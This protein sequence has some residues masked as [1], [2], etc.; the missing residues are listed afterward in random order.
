MIAAL[1]K[2][3]HDFVAADQP[4]SARSGTRLTRLVELRDDPE[5]PVSEKFRKVLEALLVETEY[6]NT[7]EVYQETINTGGGEMLVD[8][9]RLGRVGLFYQS[10]R[11]YILRL[12]QCRR[13]GLA[14]PAGRLPAA[15]RGGH[16]DRCQTAAGGTAHPAPREDVAVMKIFFQI[17]IVPVALFFPGR[18]ERRW[19][20]GYAGAA[21]GPG[22]PRR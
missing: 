15:D 22:T 10:P 13:Q 8:I 17:L 3:L 20:R 9:F 18:P 12:L 16:G 2:E 6:G 21:G 5:V 19:C 1:I 7:I 14:T 11:P 4:F